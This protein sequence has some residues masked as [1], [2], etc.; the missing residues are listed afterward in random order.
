MRS[1]RASL[2]DAPA[3]APALRDV[4]VA[5]SRAGASRFST[6]RSPSIE[7]RHFQRGNPSLAL[8]EAVFG[9]ISL[10]TRPFAAGRVARPP[11]RRAPRG[12][13]RVSRGRAAS[14]SPTASRTN[15]A[16]SACANARAPSA[17]CATASPHGSPPNRS[18]DACGCCRALRAG[19][20][21]VRRASARWL[22]RDVRS[23][24]PERCAVGPEL[25]DLLLT[26]GHWCSTQRR[27]SGASKPAQALDEALATL[28]ARARTAAP[29]GWPEVQA[30][31][32]RRASGRR[33]LSRRPTSGSGTPAATRADRATS[34]PGRTYP[35]RYVP[36]PAHTRDAAPF[37]YY[38]F[39]RSPAPFDR[40][41]M[42]DYVVTPID[43]D[44]PPTSRSAACARPTRA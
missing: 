8:G 24:S 16:R 36:I 26:R 33:R 19:A 21:R 14:R 17:C 18:T 10:I 9:V 28:D 7:S 39:Y 5:R 11:A 42:H 40:L 13:A 23:A 37:L 38:L 25:F 41:P 3:D 2:D 32:R 35:I 22:E 15:G 1:I 12:D 34:S 43:A 27:V 4:D 29:G 20:P 6:F 31:L 30:R 44:M